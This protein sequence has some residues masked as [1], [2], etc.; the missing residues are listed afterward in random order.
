MCLGVQCCWTHFRRYSLGVWT[1]LVLLVLGNMQVKYYRHVLPL[2]EISLQGRP[3][4]PRPFEVHH[5]M[6]A[7]GF[8]GE[9]QWMIG[10]NWCSAHLDEVLFNVLCHLWVLWKSHTHLQ[11]TL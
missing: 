11:G 10:G 3:P 9:F 2:I 5:L 4:W 8:H 1:A 6:H 7:I